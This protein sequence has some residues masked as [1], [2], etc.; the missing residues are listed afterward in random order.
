MFAWLRGADLRIHSRLFHPAGRR[1]TAVHRIGIG[2]R[3][4]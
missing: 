4:F 3:D 2:S 1:P